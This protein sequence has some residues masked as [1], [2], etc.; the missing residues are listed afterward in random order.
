MQN[1]YFVE[2]LLMATFV[3]IIRVSEYGT[4]CFLKLRPYDAMYT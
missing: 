1:N 2:R 4:F 3:N